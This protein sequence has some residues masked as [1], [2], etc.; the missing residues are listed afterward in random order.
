[1]EKTEKIR[2]AYN[3]KNTCHQCFNDIEFPILGDFANGEMI[4]QTKDAK[5]FF[6]AVLIDN[7][8]FDFIVDI[9][10]HK[11]EFETKK[12]DLHKILALIA[13][14]ADNKEFTTDYPICKSK[15]LNYDD[16]IRTTKIELSFATWTDFENLSHESKL[17]KLK[18]VIDLYTKPSKFL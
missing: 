10:Q 8:T 4:F 3:F 12:S 18:E 2:T 1:M 17:I 14:R 5:N 11:K 7:K 16:N 15:Q 9:L 6:I 13:D